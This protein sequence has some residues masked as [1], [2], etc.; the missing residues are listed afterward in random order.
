[1]KGTLYFLHHSGFIFETETMIWVFDYYQDPAHRLQELLKNTQKKVYFFVSHVH[2]DH[3][4]PEIGRYE[5][6]TCRYI[7]HED[8]HLP[9]ADTS[10][11]HG[12]VPGDTWQDE[13]FQVTMY[14]S[15]DVGGS[16]L[17]RGKN[18]SLFHA[19][20]LNWWH[21]AGEPD[22]DNEA[23]R[24]AFFEE[25]GK[26][27]Q[28][29]VDI[30]LLPVDARQAVAREWGVKQFLHYVHPSLLVPM[31]AFGP[32]WVPSYEFRWLYPKQKLWI[33]GEDGT[34]IK[35]SEIC[36]DSF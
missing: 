5:K 4:N 34:C 31:H 1:M 2:G 3:F 21:W 35:L 20:D 18:I 14:G 7:M 27:G 29:D 33:P 22:A 11:V 17:I 26:L 9:V 19:G 12:M 15:T 23:A 6:E 25:L 32:T 13:D 8:C 24:E 16:F 36:D 30:A 28:Q 10:K